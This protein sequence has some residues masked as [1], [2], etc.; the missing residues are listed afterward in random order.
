VKFKIS[1]SVREDSV[2]VEGETIEQ[3]RDNAFAE[4]RKRNWKET[5]CFSEEL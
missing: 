2:V 1:N 3:V 5:D 4:M